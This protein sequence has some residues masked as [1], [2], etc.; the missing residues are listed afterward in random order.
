MCLKSVHRPTLRPLPLKFYLYIVETEGLAL[1]RCAS[2]TAARNAP[3]SFALFGGS[4]L[5]KEYIFQLEN[6]N[7]DTFFLQ[8]FVESISARLR[9]SSISYN[10][11][12][13][14]FNLYSILTIFSVLMLSLFR[15]V[16]HSKKYKKS[17]FHN[18]R[19]LKKFRIQMC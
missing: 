7:N 19:G 15:L 3:G 4:A 13:S 16:S 2:L 11:E 6:Y 1:Y 17:T 12:S 8:N 14:P 5:A 9:V 10:Y 18:S